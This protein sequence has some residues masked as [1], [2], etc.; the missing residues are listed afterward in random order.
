MNVFEKSSG[1]VGVVPES[2]WIRV[3]LPSPY[4]GLGA[5][6]M[7]WAKLQAKAVGI[8]LAEMFRESLEPR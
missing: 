3:K 2:A 4:P 6:L 8:A 7:F 1:F 5:N